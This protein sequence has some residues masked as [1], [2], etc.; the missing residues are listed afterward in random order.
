MCSSVPGRDRTANHQCTPGMSGAPLTRDGSRIPWVV[1]QQHSDRMGTALGLQTA[2]SI[3]T[4]A[5]SAGTYVVVVSLSQI[6]RPLGHRRT[7]CDGIENLRSRIVQESTI[8]STSQSFR[9]DIV[10]SLPYRETSCPLEKMSRY[11]FSYVDE[12]LYFIE[13]WP[14]P[15]S[16]G[17]RRPDPCHLFS[18]TGDATATIHICSI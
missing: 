7:G 6:T 16:I 8:I 2:F 15:G 18:F 3:L 10:S 12:D 13:V 14:Q 5:K 1:W 4:L 9:Q 11:T 17:F